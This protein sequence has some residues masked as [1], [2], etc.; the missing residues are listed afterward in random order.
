[1]PVDVCVQK[2]KKYLKIKWIRSMYANV[3]K[4]KGPKL[5][6]EK[7]RLHFILSMKITKLI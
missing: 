3:L 2:K 5:F 7:F 6:F 4:L 1:M